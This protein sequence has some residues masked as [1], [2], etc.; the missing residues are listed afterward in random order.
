MPIFFTKITDSD[1]EDK[2][3]A[4]NIKSAVEEAEIGEKN[5][6]KEAQNLIG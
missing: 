1:C 5:E 3:E 6:E 4:E 2:P